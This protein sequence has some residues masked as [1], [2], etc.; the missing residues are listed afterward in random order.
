MRA[1]RQE[2]RCPWLES[3]NDHGSAG[4]HAGCLHAPSTSV[5]GEAYLHSWAGGVSPESCKQGRS[6]SQVWLIPGIWVAS[7]MG[8]AL[9]ESLLP[10]QE[11]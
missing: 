3:L 10:T 7:S 2:E 9:P 8:R 11:Q 6:Q 4:L 5:L 1:A